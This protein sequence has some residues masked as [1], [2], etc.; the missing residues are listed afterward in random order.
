MTSQNIEKPS[1]SKSHDVIRLSAKRY[2]QSPYLSKYMVDDAIFGLYA[3]RFYP[4]SLGGDP[5]NE[6][7]NLR[8]K[9]ML[10]DVPEKP[11]EIKGADAVKL[12]EGV[13]T[14][15]IGSLKQWRARYAIACTPRGGILM[16]GVLI[17]LAEDHFWYVQADGEFETWLL[18]HSAGLDVTIRDPKSWV[19]QIQGPNSLKILEA[20]SN[21]SIDDF[22]Y[23]HAGEFDF[24]G[25]NLLVTRTGWTGETG[26]E[27]YSRPEIDH[28]GL[29]DYLLEV[30][31]PF[32]LQFGSL[33]SMGMRRIEAGILDN[34]TDIDPSMNPFEAGLGMF[35]NFKKDDFVGREALTNTNQA[36]LLFGLVTETG[37]P[38]T[39]CD[40]LLAGES[41][42]RMTTGGWSPTLE[43]GIGYVRFARPHAEGESW[44][45]KGITLV[46]RQGEH[47]LAEVVT[48]PFYDQEKLIPRGLKESSGDG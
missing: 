20:A 48:L 22:G 36:Q 45:G 10:Y 15:K 33:E 28:L 12:L 35:V 29:W 3:S 4:L 31:R 27:I 25:E 8:K 13:F 26:F 47:H 40:V 37:M 19:L 9:A 41:V 24:N 34:G 21:K 1:Y 14:R 44:L 11:L 16:D 2:E 30:G 6:Y 39:N 5:I 43:K 7:W 46:D 42:G 38:Q 17:R 23:F 32:G 18:A